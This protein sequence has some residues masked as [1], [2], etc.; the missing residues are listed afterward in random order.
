M[1]LDFRSAAKKAQ[2]AIIALPMFFAFNL[3][4]QNASK[5][6]IAMVTTPGDKAKTEIK[7]NAKSLLSE[8]KDVEVIQRMTSGA[9][10]DASANSDALYISITF[11]RGTEGKPKEKIAAHVRSLMLK[12]MGESEDSQKIIVG[13]DSTDVGEG[14]VFRVY[15]AFKEY[16][17]NGGVLYDG[18]S[19]LSG[20]YFMKEANRIY[21]LDFHKESQASRPSSE[22]KI[23]G[24]DKD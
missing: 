19:N 16:D 3:S 21:I 18:D 5:A 12:T 8:K 4:A 24:L 17:R 2:A 9:A 6:D 10:Q 20:N 23:T 1:K 15:S 11:G 13:L 7:A 22:Y 14:Y